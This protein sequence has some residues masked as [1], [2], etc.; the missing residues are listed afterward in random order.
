VKYPYPNNI[1]TNYKK[2][3]NKG[4]G[5]GSENIKDAEHRKMAFNLEKEHKII[6]P[7][8]MELKTTA[9]VDFKPFSVIP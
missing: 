4:N 7:H 6:N 5:A 8:K 2:D 9:K 3:Y 1:I